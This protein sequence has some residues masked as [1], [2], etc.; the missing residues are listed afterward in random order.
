VGGRVTRSIVVRPASQINA[1]RDAA[2]HTRVKQLA[3][4][5]ALLL[6]AYLMAVS[7]GSPSYWWL[8]WITLLP[9]FH[10]IR[11]SRPLPAGL[12]GGLWGASLFVCSAVIGNNSIDPSAFSL[13]SLSLIPGLY[14]ALGAWL[15]RRVGFSP[16]LLALGW[17][18]VE[19]ALRPLGL[20][21]GLLAATQGDGFALRVVGSFAGYVL[22]AFV[23]AYV[24]AALVSV[25]SEVRLSFVAPRLIPKAGARQRRFL[26][27][28]LPSYLLDLIRAAQPRAPPI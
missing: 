4:V 7:I 26:L 11:V 14:A 15:T 13:V 24:N 2:R 3:M 1:G 28:E 12:A 18:G 8:G 6:G 21:F 20:H 10:A 16:Y 17:I 27:A 23:V 25:L 5:A 19:F 22:V 9:L